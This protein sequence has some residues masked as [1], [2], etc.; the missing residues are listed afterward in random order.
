M[1]AKNAIIVILLAAVAVMG[2][3]L[4]SATPKPQGGETSS[5]KEKLTQAAGWDAWP[6]TFFVGRDGLVRGAHAGFPGPGSGE[7]YKL[8]TDEFIAKVEHLLA[9]N[10]TSSR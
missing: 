1:N 3:F 9:E 8:E 5:A 6:T 2:I 7:L 4:L 10:Q